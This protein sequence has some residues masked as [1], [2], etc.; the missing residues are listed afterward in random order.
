MATLHAKIS[1]AKSGLRIAGYFLL[2]LISKEALPAV[3]VLVASEIIGV[4]E[5]IG[6]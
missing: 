3:I 4:V 1:Y 2:L 5:E 6:H